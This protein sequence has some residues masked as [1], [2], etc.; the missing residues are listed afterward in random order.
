MRNGKEIV[1][2]LK[3][4]SVLLSLY[5]QYVSCTSCNSKITQSGLC[6]ICQVKPLSKQNYFD[7]LEQPIRFRIDIRE[8]RKKFLVEQAKW[9]PD[10]FINKSP[11]EREESDLKSAKLNKA[12]EVI[13]DPLSRAHYLVTGIDV[14]KVAGEGD[15]R[16][17]TTQR[18]SFSDGH[19]GDSRECV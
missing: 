13:K 12:Y 17:N 16:A 3:R 7:L 4:T 8:L 15:Y 1:D 2:M 14:A 10:L 11:T 6:N 9:H 18:S 5:K 19:Y